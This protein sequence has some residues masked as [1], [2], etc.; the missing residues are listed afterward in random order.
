MNLYYDDDDWQNS[1]PLPQDVINKLLGLNQLIFLCS[2]LICLLTAIK[3]D[4]KTVYN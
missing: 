3:D 4:R 2:F 1:T